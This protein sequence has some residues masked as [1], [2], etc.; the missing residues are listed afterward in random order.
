MIVARPASSNVSPTVPRV[1]Y[2]CDANNGNAAANDERIA[3][4]LA[5]AD[6]GHLHVEVM[7]PMNMIGNPSNTRYR[8]PK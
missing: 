7:L 3:E 6:A 8:I 2:I 1:S 4:L 5:I